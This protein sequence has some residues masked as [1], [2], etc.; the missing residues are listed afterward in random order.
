MLKGF[1]AAFTTSHFFGLGDQPWWVRV[2][3]TAAT[4]AALC[5]AVEGVRRLL[6]RRKTARA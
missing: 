2:L 6:N 4:L 1:I 5:L 3:V